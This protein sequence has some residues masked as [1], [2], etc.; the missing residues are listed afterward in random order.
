MGPRLGR[1]SEQEPGPGVDT[2]AQTP[3]PG[4]D[5]AA[6]TPGHQHSRSTPGDGGS[7]QSAVGGVGERGKRE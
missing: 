4:V 5:T 6:Q 1:C 3:G 2:E 7:T